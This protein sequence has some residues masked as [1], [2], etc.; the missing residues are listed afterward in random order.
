M[1]KCKF[2]IVKCFFIRGVRK[3]K[4]RKTEE[5]NNNE[6]KDFERIFMQ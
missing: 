3:K 2:S 5:Q 1:R 4:K 6:R